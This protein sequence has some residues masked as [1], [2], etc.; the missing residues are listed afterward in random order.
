MKFTIGIPAYKAVFFRECL[1]SVLSQNYLDYEVVIVNDASPFDIKPIVNS[2]NSDKIRYFE[3]SYNCGALNV[4][5][6]WNICL[7]KARGEYF[8]LMGDDDV[9]CPDYLSEFAQLIER[10][11]TC[12][13]YHCRSYIIN[14]QSKVVSLTETRPEIESVYD[15]VLQ[16]LKGHRLFFI[17]DYVFKTDALRANGS[18][19]KLP[20]AWASDDITAYIAAQHNGTAHTNKAVFCYRQSPQTISTSGNVYQKLEAI[21]MEEMWLRSFVKKVPVDCDD[22]IIMECLQKEITISMKK[23]RLRTISASNHSNALSLIATWFPR[24]KEY[25]VSFDELI[26]SAIMFIKEKKK[27]RYAGKD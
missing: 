23:K 1:Q 4:V 20:L 13:V 8:V 16:R 10:F 18:F 24:R 21:N 19:Y 5:D 7:S 15:S 6:N 17:S 11:P 3:N 25:N 12:H 26:Y 9:M 27:D 14:E 22:R 2:F